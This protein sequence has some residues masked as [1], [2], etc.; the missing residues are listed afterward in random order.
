MQRDLKARVQ[1]EQ[2]PSIV[3]QHAGHVA[4]AAFVDDHVVDA[5]APRFPL[6]GLALSFH[7]HSDA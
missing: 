3:A 6:I 5:K 4:E 2:T 1:L 7:Q